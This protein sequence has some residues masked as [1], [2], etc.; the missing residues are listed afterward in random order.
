MQTERSAKTTHIETSW[1]AYCIYCAS[2]ALELEL[3]DSCSD[4]AAVDRRQV[5]KRWCRELELDATARRQA[6]AHP[7]LSWTWSKSRT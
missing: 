2:K 6:E 5:A 4:V 1:H 3:L 7:C